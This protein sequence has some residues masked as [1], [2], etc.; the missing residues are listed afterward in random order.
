VLF[1]QQKTEDAIK[2]YAE[3]GCVHIVDEKL[4]SL[5]SAKEAIKLYEI[6]HRVSS[7]MYREMIK[8]VQE[9]HPEVVDLYSFIKKH[10]DFEKYVHEKGMER[11]AAQFILKNA[12]ECRP[13]LEERCLDPLKIALTVVDKTQSKNVQRGEEQKTKKLDH[14]IGC[15][16]LQGRGLRFVHRLKKS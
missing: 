4:P 2:T 12:E 13:I 9:E 14:L 5:G 3:K 15:K 16:D 6:S 1:G 7:L 8:D 10:Q 11:K